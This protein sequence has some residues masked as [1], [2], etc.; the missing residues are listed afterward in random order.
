MSKRAKLPLIFL[1]V[2][3]C[4][5]LLPVVGL[6][7]GNFDWTVYSQ[8]Y[9]PP[10]APPTGAVCVYTVR[11]G[12]TLFSIARRF[13]TSVTSIAQANAIRDVNQI[14][15]GQVLVIPNCRLLQCAVYVVKPGDTLFSI[16]RR[17]GTS[18]RALA[19]QNA[20][21]NPSRIFVGQRLL[22]CPGVARPLPKARIYIVKRGDTV[23][24]IAIRFGTT[25]AAIIA[26]NNLR[27]PWLIFPGQRLLIP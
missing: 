26:A 9:P 13:G 19:F 24:S 25:Q 5:L 21:L 11:F 15:V 2:I 22:I 20:I 6:P 12:D 3:A 7:Y 16:A 14:F 8:P 1:T 23:W 27:Y 4:L 17:F 10:K 18:V